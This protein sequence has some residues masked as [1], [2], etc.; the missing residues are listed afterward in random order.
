MQM[1]GEGKIDIQDK[2]IGREMIFNIQ[3]LKVK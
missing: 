1:G 3:N 2:K